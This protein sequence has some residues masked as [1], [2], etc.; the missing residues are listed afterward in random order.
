MVSELGDVR[1]RFLGAHE[2]EVLTGAIRLAYGETYDEPWV[3]D[4]G[5]VSRRIADGRLVSC[6][7]EDDR[8]GLLCH[9]GLTLHSRHDEVGHAGQAI[10]VPAVRGHHLFTDVKRYL[11]TWAGGQGMVGMYS[12]ATA[13]HPYSQRANVDLGAHETGFLLGWIPDSVT[14]DAAVDRRGRQSAAL[15]FLRMNHGHT[16]PVYVPPRHRDTVHQI[17]S[18]CGLRGRLAE[19]SP[20][21]RLVAHTRMHTELHRGHN[22]AVITAIEPGADLLTVVETA[23]RRLF[24][25]GIAAIYLDLP[26]DSPTT[27][28]VAGHLEELGVSFSG[29]FPNSR[30]NGDVL[31][32]Q[33]LNGITVVADDVSVAS[34][35]GRDLLAYV[36]DDLAATA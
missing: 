5:D 1:I 23:R 20:H 13:A 4:V 9:A 2:A 6:V 28:L 36:L 10:T 15:F 18:I 16:R 30:A 32:M 14:N 21:L 8:G 17:L 7:A 22:L 3:Y 11:A 33:S 19:P 29:I 31:R 35:H 26:L 27:A 12:E 24:D 25:S 34:D